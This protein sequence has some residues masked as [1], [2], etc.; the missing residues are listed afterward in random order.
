MMTRGVLVIDD[1]PFIRNV[2]KD[3][4]RQAGFPFAG[5]AGDGREGVES[6]RRLRP[7]VTLLDITMPVLDGISALGQ[8]MQIDPDSR[9]VMC[10]AIG[11]QSMI[12]RAIRLGA[13]DFIVKPFKPEQIVTTI[14]NALRR[15]PRRRFSWR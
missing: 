1:I 15:N 2:L 9:V 4:I 13:M 6:F 5:E 14:Q 7:D 12:I 8:I 10:S 11:E 3:I